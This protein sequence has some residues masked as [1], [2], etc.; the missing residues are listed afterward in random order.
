MRTKSVLT[1]VVLVL[2]IVPWVLTE[3]PHHPKK[4]HTS[5]AQKDDAHFKEGKHQEDFDHEAILG[6]REAEEE[7]YELSDDEA[8]ERLSEIFDKI[9]TNGDHHVSEDELVHCILASFKKLDAS[10]A[11][12]RFNGNDADKDGQVTWKEFV[13]N[14]YEY[15]LEEVEEFKKDHSEEMRTFLDSLEAEHE[16]FL[17]ADVN[18][19]GSLDKNEYVAFVNPHEHE[20]MWNVE[21]KQTLKDYDTNKDGSV[22]LNEFMRQSAGET[23]SKETLIA[24]QENF[25]AYDVNK[26]GKLDMQE[27]RAWSLPNNLQNAKD[28][29]EHLMSETDFDH[30]KILTR[31]EVLE[32]HELWVGS[33]A[34]EHATHDPSEL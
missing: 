8:K 26:D 3:Q 34:Y 12:E 21:L 14:V 4:T 5:H 17:A 10:D 15:S 18:K 32:Q 25:G 23:P 22:D 28:E 2:C 1:K 24:E 33:Q 19:N 9:D 6:S 20:H 7:F 11:L 13:K 29:A 31:D 16:K 27:M 30:D